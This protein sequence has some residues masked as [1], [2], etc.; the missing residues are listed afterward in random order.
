M[1]IIITSC[2]KLYRFLRD[3]YLYIRRLPY[4]HTI[5]KYLSKDTSIISS[6]CFAGRIM[7]DLGMEY[8]TPTL[9]LWIM[10]DD[11]PK[12]CMELRRYM[13]ID[14]V[15]K[16][17]SKN[18]LGEQKHAN[19]STHHYY[20]IGN[21]GDVEIH[22][23][24]YH[25]AEEAFAKWKRRANRVNYDN[26]FF[27]GM[28]QNGCTEDDIKAFDVLP[29]KRKIFFCSKPY[30]YKSV[31]YIKEFKKLGHVGDPYKKGYIFYKYLAEWLRTNP[32]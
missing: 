8:N 22:Y 28:E 6:N 11:Y 32:T 27:I 23:L 16:E 26:L 18:A 21:V 13:C 19:P 1:N 15:L 17:H 31:V 25:S 29:Y 5:N 7:Q 20:P 14:P 30:N 4:L 10:P 24:H 9:G 3:T 12:M 2:L